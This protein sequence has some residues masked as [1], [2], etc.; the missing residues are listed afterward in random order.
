MGTVQNAECR[1][2][3]E[4]L[5][6]GN[7]GNLPK[8]QAGCRERGTGRQKDSG[9]GAL[10]EPDAGAAGHSGLPLVQ[11]PPGNQGRGAGRAGLE[12][13]NRCQPRRGGLHSSH[14]AQARGT[15]TGVSPF[16]LSAP[17]GRL[18]PRIQSPRWGSK[19]KRKRGVAYASLPRACATGLQINRAYGT[20]A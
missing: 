11:A 2:Q 3:S 12:T 18:R 19:Q 4:K 8:R 13:G 1:M 6:N 16:F 17:S 20:G 9:T 14:G 7:S 10:F 15:R 5:N